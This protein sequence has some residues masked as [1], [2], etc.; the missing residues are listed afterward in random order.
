[1]TNYHAQERTEDAAHGGHVVTLAVFGAWD[2]VKMPE[3]LVGSINQVDFHNAPSEFQNTQFRPPCPMSALAIYHSLTNQVISRLDAIA[4]PEKAER[5]PLWTLNA[6]PHSHLA[7]RLQQSFFE[8]SV[9]LP[10]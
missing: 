4:Q 5:S 7:S 3:E 8:V 2:G 6:Q 9:V 1:L 10:K